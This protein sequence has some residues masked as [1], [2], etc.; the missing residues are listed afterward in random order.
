MAL[1]TG[2]VCIKISGREAGKYCVVLKKM[3]DKKN[4]SFVL[5]TGPKALT[6]VKRRRCNVAH[7]EPLPY[8]LEISENASDEEI[9]AAF[10]K[11][12]LIKKLNLKKP[13][14]TQLKPKKTD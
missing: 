14:A 10:E 13:S 9:I 12:N 8:V 6:G 11:S 4:K 7:L 3:E 2:R 1:E 5:I